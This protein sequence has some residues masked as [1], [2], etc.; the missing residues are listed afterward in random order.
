MG[1]VVVL[2]VLFEVCWFYVGGLGGDVGVCVFV[3]VVV[4]GGFG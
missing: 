1:C 2:V 3:C 4:V